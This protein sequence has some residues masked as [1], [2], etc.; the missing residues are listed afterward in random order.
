MQKPDF[1]GSF[2]VQGLSMPAPSVKLPPLVKPPLPPPR[3]VQSNIPQFFTTTTPTL[4]KAEADKR[5][6]AATEKKK[7][8]TR[9]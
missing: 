9:K 2:A 8:A 1:T 6:K 4:A 3:K 7:E 5:A